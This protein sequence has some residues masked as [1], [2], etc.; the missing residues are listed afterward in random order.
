MTSVAFMGL[1][2]MGRGMAARLIEQRVPLVVWNRSRERADALV[3][4]SGS[5]GARVA[6]S[7][8]EAA[9]AADIVLSMVAD[10]RASRAVWLGEDGALAG[11]KPQTV[12][13]ESST[14]SP[15]WIEELAA[16]AAAR[17][18]VLLDAP[19]TG[20]RPQA[21]S[22]QLL[23]LVGGA[24][25]PLER[26]RPV[27][28][29]MSRAILHLGPTGSGSRLKLVNNFVCGV[30]A[31]ALAEA[32]AMIERTGLNRDLATSVLA[33]GAPGS[34]LVKALGP[35]M[36]SADPTVHFGLDL[37]RKDLSYAIA[38]ADRFGLRLETAAAARDRFSQASAAGLGGKDFSAV[39]DGVRKQPR[40]GFTAPP[41][42]S[43]Q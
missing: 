34:P 26:A 1:G 2:V 41:A 7:P 8:R 22:G 9:A 29:M 32:V 28:A 42:S 19:V 35:R 43:S 3:A 14:L 25:E 24:A 30:Q 23:F 37:M 33:E 31:V 6:A 4:E 16:R 39:V 13:V 40:P 10:D 27:L 38:E 20:S 17:G 12:L 5:A 21:A 11:A 18:C 15:A 36:T